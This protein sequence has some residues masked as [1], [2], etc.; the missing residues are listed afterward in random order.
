MDPW[1]LW[2]PDSPQWILDSQ[3]KEISSLFLDV[4]LSSWILGSFKDWILDSDSRIPDQI[5]ITIL[6]SGL[7]HM[8]RIE[9]NFTHFLS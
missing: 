6:D 8:G 5:K 9:A 7:P 4:Y 2:I 3:S 1:A